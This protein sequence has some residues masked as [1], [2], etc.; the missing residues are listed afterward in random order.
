MEIEYTASRSL[1][2]VVHK[3]LG[4]GHERHDTKAMRPLAPGALL[5]LSMARARR[6][7]TLFLEN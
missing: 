6:A 5:R 4:L 1:L 7:Q 3:A 2:A